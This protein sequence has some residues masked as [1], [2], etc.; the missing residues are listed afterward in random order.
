[1]KKD[2]I[3]PFL[4]ISAILLNASIA[5]CAGGEPYG[6]EEDGYSPSAQ[7]VAPENASFE[8]QAHCWDSLHHQLLGQLHDSL[9]EA[10]VSGRCAL[11]I[12]M[13]DVVHMTRTDIVG[14]MFKAKSEGREE[15][16]KILRAQ[17][18]QFD[19]LF[20]SMQRVFSKDQEIPK[21]SDVQ[22][23]ERVYVEGLLGYLRDVSSQ[24]HLLS[25]KE[26]RV[27]N[28]MRSD[29]PVPD[30]A[31]DLLVNLFVKNRHIL[32]QRAILSEEHRNELDVAIANSR[33]EEES[34]MDADGVHEDPA[35]TSMNG[36][37]MIAG[38]H[39]LYAQGTVLAEVPEATPKKKAKP[40]VI[41]KLRSFL[42][43][44]SI[45]DRG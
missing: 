45:F 9:R 44:F 17:L 25:L 13:V 6:Y 28:E 37:S 30:G 26:R 43:G 27:L 12:N 8:A 10:T 11:L 29:T 15:E 3:R 39:R 20:D 22:K 19:D 18:K 34:K 41:S 14:R 38:F 40:P 1:M 23:N 35:A 5:F 4:Y 16:E 33:G 2:Y 24:K 32:Q 7:G 31:S 42:S 36:M 21:A